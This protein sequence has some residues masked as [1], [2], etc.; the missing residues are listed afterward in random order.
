[1]PG[2]LGIEKLCARKSNVFRRTLPRGKLRAAPFYHSQ[3]NGNEEREGSSARKESP[4]R[5]LLPEGIFLRPLARRRSRARPT[6]GARQS[7]GREGE[8]APTLV[9]RSSFAP[10]L[11]GVVCILSPSSER[12]GIEAGCALE[13]R[14]EGRQIFAGRASLGPDERTAPARARALTLLGRRI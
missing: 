4:E 14:G 1:M 10:T 5:A 6:E 8:P 12:A 9:G 11:K 13:W 3:N 7:S 2:N